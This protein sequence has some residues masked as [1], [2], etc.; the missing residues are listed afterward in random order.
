MTALVAAQR[1]IVFVGP[2]F[3]TARVRELVPSAEVRPP[4]RRGDLSTIEAPAVVAM[5]DGTQDTE[6][7]ITTR[8]I[9]TAIARGVRIA[10][11]S[12]IGALRAVEVPEMVGV[13]RIYEM[14]RSSLLQ[15]DDEVAVLFDA[16][17][18]TALTDALVNIRFAV[19]A[20]VR[21]GTLDGQMGLSIVSAAS[22]LHFHERTYS[23]IL[24]RAGLAGLKDAQHLVSILRSFDL[25]REDAQTLLERL[26]DLGSDTRWSRPYLTNETEDPS[27]DHDESDPFRMN[28]AAD[29]PLCIWEFGEQISWNDLFVF[30]GAT[31]R[32]DAHVRR[33]FARMRLDDRNQTEMQDESPLPSVQ[34]LFRTTMSE[35]DWNAADEVYLTL[36]DLGIGFEDLQAQLQNERVMRRS[37]LAL[38]GAR[39][40]AFMRALRC[41]LFIT[42][43]A[44]KREAMRLGSLQV[45]AQA[46]PGAPALG[47]TELHDAKRALLCERP[48][49]TWEGLLSESGLHDVD[50]RGIV[51]LVASARRVGGAIIDAMKNAPTSEGTASAEAI[52]LPLAT[53]ANGP[54]SRS[55][56]D[57]AASVTARRLGDVIGVTR[58]ARLG[59]LGRFGMHVAAAYRPSTWSSTIG[60][61][62][63]ES[64]EGAVIGALMEELEKY[65]QEHFVPDL[66]VSA[67]FLD[68]GPERAVDPRQCALPFDSSYA[69]TASI[70]WS[71]MLDLVT[72]KRVLVPTAL[73]S[74]R[75][76]RND[77]LY[78]PRRGARV[79]N[80]NG[81]ASS[82]TITEALV[83]ALCERVERH[84]VK[85]AEQA[86]SNPGEMGGP[87]RW[88]FTFIDL[89]RCPESTRTIVSG[90]RRAGYEA[91]AMDITCEVGVPTF[92]VRLFRPSAIHGIAG[93]YGSGSCA[94]PDPEHAMNR[95]LLEA[96]QTCISALS[97]A[98]EDVGVQAR[99]L[100]RHERPRPLSRG[101]AYWIRPHVPK[102]PLSNVIG[103]A[104]PNARDELEFIVRRITA[105]GFD[106]VLYR[107]LSR[108]ETAPAHVVRAFVPGMEDTNP[109][110]TGLR[111]R[112]LMVQD[113]LQQ[114]EW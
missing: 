72:A 46:A 59:E 91:R 23:N 61:G 22:T 8:E 29:A 66:V 54:S 94:H 58:V 35:W 37:L 15:R 48:E 19:D 80:T 27:R 114:H 2:S 85:L 17:S 98:R 88:P 6:S 38:S 112:A 16:D 12:S 44:L 49:L 31:G 106:R 13:G 110:H 102:K 75:R 105:A 74:M 25:K 70:D 56:G 43:L 97:G 5:I 82:F 100:G 42:D 107:D 57:V 95:A 84:A 89:E 108:D 60:S 7:V 104:A 41:E 51:A 3:P 79:F 64:L 30:L 78:S 28:E 68:I 96:V 26:T 63:S 11:S 65:C 40:D 90:I 73:L 81:L 53:H 76:E 9:R 45:L 33:V 14:Y 18:G 1:V 4:I 67:P 34:E 101:D 109:F 50:T 71:W 32:L 21:A 10:G 99:S 52:L 24:D 113:L 39:D 93:K 86:V 87:S 47:E 55:M 20:V 62:K 92:S 111:A 77:V 83:H 103:L 36:K 69:A